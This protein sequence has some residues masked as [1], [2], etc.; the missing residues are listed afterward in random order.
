MGIVPVAAFAASAAGCASPV[1]GANRHAE[2]RQFLREQPPISL[3]AFLGA[4]RWRRRV[5][6]GMGCHSFGS[7]AFPLSA[8]LHLHEGYRG[9][10]GGLQ[11]LF[12][13]APGPKWSLS[14]NVLQPAATCR[15]LHARTNV[16]PGRADII[17]STRG[18]AGLPAIRYEVLEVRTGAIDFV[19]RAQVAHGDEVARTG[20]ATPVFHNGGQRTLQPA[21]SGRSLDS[22]LDPGIG[23][24]AGLAAAA[25]SANEGRRSGKV[26][27]VAARQVSSINGQG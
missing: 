9:T 26:R 6:S 4:S 12:A 10:K 1:S 15:P 21:V 27:I 17:L 14:D 5:N 2:Y 18:L 3:P 8:A 24:A 11:R 16:R 22:W 20:I 13:P 23:L 25:G 19:F 7:P